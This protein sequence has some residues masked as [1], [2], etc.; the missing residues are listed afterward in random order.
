WD[1]GARRAAAEDRQ[2]SARTK[3]PSNQA[4]LLSAS[5]PGSHLLQVTCPLSYRITGLNGGR[6]ARGKAGGG[7]R[8]DANRGLAGVH[9]LGDG[10][11]LD[12]FIES[13]VVNGG[14]KDGAPVGTGHSRNSGPLHDVVQRHGTAVDRERLPFGGTHRHSCL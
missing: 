8:F 4:T 14:A 6:L 10:A 7:K 5:R 1:Y 11:H 3:Y 2:L 9:Q 12:V 13:Y